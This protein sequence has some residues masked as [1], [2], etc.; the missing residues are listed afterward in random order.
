LDLL[1][2]NPTNVKETL[3]NLKREVIEKEI[4]VMIIL[5]RATLVFGDAIREAIPKEIRIKTIDIG[6]AK[7]QGTEERSINSLHLEDNL[8]IA[9][10]DEYISF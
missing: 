9:I 6:E 10:L 1:L 3:K 4:Q 8:R 2:P 7:K 5:E